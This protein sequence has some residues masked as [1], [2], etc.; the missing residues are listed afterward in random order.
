MEEKKVGNQEKDKV[1]DYEQTVVGRR[2]TVNRCKEKI[3]IRKEAEIKCSERKSKQQ[4]DMKKY[5][6]SRR[7]HDYKYIQIT[8]KIKERKYGLRTTDKM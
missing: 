2:G 3:K 4:Q 5:V 1:R 8:F 7:G 6:K